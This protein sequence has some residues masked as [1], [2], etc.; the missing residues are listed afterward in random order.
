[1]IKTLIT[2]LDDSDS[3]YE[4]EEEYTFP[5][6]EQSLIEKQLDNRIKLIK[7]EVDEIYEYIKSDISISIKHNE[8]FNVYFDLIRYYLIVYLSDNIKDESII[9]ELVKEFVI[10]LK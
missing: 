8:I 4:S 2:R 7:K 5:S 9:E 1:M 3:E 6:K 10:Q